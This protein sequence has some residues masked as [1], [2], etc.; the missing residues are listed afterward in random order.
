MKRVA[1]VT[2]STADIPPEVA[3]KR[4]IR[5]IPCQLLIEG[6]VYRDG[7]DMQA[8]EFYRIL[9]EDKIVPTTSQPATGDFISAYQDLSRTAES[10]VSIHISGALSGTVEFAHTAI[11]QMDAQ[12]VRGIH[13]VDSR[14]VSMAMGLVV[15]AAADMAERGL[16]A[17]EIVARVDALC[18]KVR[19]LFVVDTLKYLH[20]GGRIGG[21]E[22]FFG[23]LLSIRPLL[24]IVDGKVEALEKT[25]TKQRALARLIEVMGEWIGSARKLHL[26][27][28]HADA[29]EDAMHLKVGIEEYFHQSVPYVCEFTPVVGVHAGPGVVGAAF[30]SE[31]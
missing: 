20:R 15:L 31:E 30:Y 18:P 28:A 29:L 17:T 21:A 6:R 24:Q 4:G 26:A 27:I 23:S 5:V 19:A 1:I 16:D 8:A 25:R 3:A 13:V 9:R 7:V 2:D 14:L 11:A 12:A 10:I 22:R